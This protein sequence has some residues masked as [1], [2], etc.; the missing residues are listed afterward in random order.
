MAEVAGIDDDFHVP[1]G[2]GEFSEDGDCGILGRVIDENML[3]VVL[4]ESPHHLGGAADHF[5]NVFLL[6]VT[7]SYYA[8]RF[9]VRLTL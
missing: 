6:V 1:V 5:A 3:V 2:R 9:H 4:R 7:G 8:D